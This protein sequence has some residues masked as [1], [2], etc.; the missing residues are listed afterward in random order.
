M[1]QFIKN[2]RVSIDSLLEQSKSLPNNRETALARTNMQSGFMWLGLV[3]GAL[4]TANPYPESHNP[5]S[6]VI[7]KHADKAK[8][9]P[10][11]HEGMPAEEIAAVKWL[12]D[13]LQGHIQQLNVHIFG[14]VGGNNEEFKDVQHPG[15]IAMDKL[16]E[17]KMWW[18]QQL[19]NIREAQEAKNS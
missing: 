11:M 2:T 8:D 19:S 4:G 12:R 14:Y 7:E 1:E 13:K 9:D 10:G 5:D 18:G 15:R 17:A 16:I 3:L 6:K